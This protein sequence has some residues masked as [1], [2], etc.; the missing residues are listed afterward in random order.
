MI[1]RDAMFEQVT[2]LMRETATR[3]IMPRFRLLRD[4]EI[5]EKSPG[6]VVTVADRATEERLT[7]GLRALIPTAQFVAEESWNLGAADFASLAGAD[8]VWVVDPLDGTANFAS[9]QTTFAVMVALLHRGEAVASWIHAPADD[10]TVVAQAGA[11]AY[12][13]GQ[14]LHVS[15]QTALS[16][17]HGAIHD[18]FMPLELRQHVA[19][20]VPS[21]GQSSTT[22]CAAHEYVKIARGAKDFVLYYRTLP[23]DH[24]PGVLVVQ[25]AG[26]IVQHYDSQRYHPLKAKSGLLAAANREAWQALRDLFVGNCEVGED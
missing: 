1:I 8:T 16:A 4:D 10:W 26:G 15:E 5:M 20:A 6:E 24:A 12:L 23:W 21:I 9:G 13:D 17:M 3:E 14:R 19:A 2:D 25:E 18:H 22:G 7:H 11:G